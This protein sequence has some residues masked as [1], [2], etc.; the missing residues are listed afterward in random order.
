MESNI[1]IIENEGLYNVLVDN[2][3]PEDTH[4]LK[5]LIIKNFNIT[6]IKGTLVINDKGEVLI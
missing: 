2:L 5:S 3:S 6:F 4:K 1:D